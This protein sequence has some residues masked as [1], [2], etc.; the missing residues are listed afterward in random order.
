MH[1]RYFKAVASC[2]LAI[3]CASATTLSN[4]AQWISFPAGTIGNQGY[5][6]ALA[7]LS[8]GRFVLGDEGKLYVQ[9]TWGLAPRT[10]IT[11]TGVTFDPS[12]VALKSDTSGLVGGGGYPSP[13]G[14]Y[15]FNPAAPST[16]VTSTSLTASPLQNYA[17]VYWRNP[18]QGG[19]EGWIIG[20]LNDG[21]GKH[22][23]TYVSSDGQ[24]VGAVTGTL[25]TYSS[26]MCT[27]A[28]G[29]VYAALSEFGTADAQD[30]E[31]VLKFTSSQIET[32]VAAVLTGMPAP[33][34]RASAT[35]VHQ[36]LGAA[37]IALD[38]T[39]RLWAASYAGYMEVYD[40][41][42]GFT[43]QITPDHPAIVGAA[44]HTAYQLQ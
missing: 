15:G 4:A 18:A 22:N 17:A 30:S 10:E 32:A 43:R 26:G 38:A 33:V 5:G 44:G 14:L 20:G 13:L 29:N 31:K 40:P 2:A 6:F 41:A 27:D 16:L 3:A 7:R 35:L 37:S 25:S 12:F 23:L 34:D 11:S 39:G 42:N 9:N 24:K 19:H 8:D 28:A 36:F 1:Y 21:N